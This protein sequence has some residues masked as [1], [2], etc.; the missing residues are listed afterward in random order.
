MPLSNLSFGRP[1]IEPLGQRTSSRGSLINITAPCGVF[2]ML[3]ESA[4]LVR[5]GLCSNLNF[6]NTSFPVTLSFQSTGTSTGWTSGYTDACQTYN[7]GAGCI[8]VTNSTN[9]IPFSN[10][11][12]ASYFNFNTFETLAL[13]FVTN[14]GSGNNASSLWSQ[15]NASTMLSNSAVTTVPVPQSFGPSIGLTCWGSVILTYYSTVPGSLNGAYS[16]VTFRL[17]SDPPN[18]MRNDPFV[19]GPYDAGGVI[20]WGLQD[21]STGTLSFSRGFTTVTREVLNGVIWQYRLLNQTTTRL[22]T[23]TDACNVTAS[24]VQTIHLG[25]VG[26]CSTTIET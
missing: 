25:T 22:Y 3:D 10:Y 7:G 8:P 23:A 1:P 6:S 24:C 2:V 11:I 13:A 16:L 4:Q 18:T 14:V 21:L 19:T 15:F 5:Y 12:R 17:S 20:N 9:V 26:T